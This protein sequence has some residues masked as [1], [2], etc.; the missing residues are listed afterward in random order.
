MFSRAGKVKHLGLSEC[1]AS[2]LR[3]AH[4]VWP[5]AAVQVEYSP[6]FMDIESPRTGLL[7]TCR[8]LGVAVIAYSPLGRGLFTGRFK[9]LSDFQEG[10]YRLTAMPRFFGEN[11]HKNL[12]L[13]RT[14]EALAERKGCTVGQM[15]LAWLMRQGEDIIPI[16]GTKSVKYL[17]ENLGALDV[18]LSD[19]ENKEIREA[20]EQAEVFGDRYN[21]AMIGMQ[22]LDTPPR[23]ALPSA[24]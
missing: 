15:T 5:I 13:V 12:H 16:P 11:F 10:D 3:R 20:V 2:T 18:V 4:A 6:L 23:G 8:E 24:A 7:Q 21:E 17:E 19:Q 1:S 9:S 22:F 14:I